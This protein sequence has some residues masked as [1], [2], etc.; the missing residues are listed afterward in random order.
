MDILE[1]VIEEIQKECEAQ[2]REWV[3]PDICGVDAI[4][5]RDEREVWVFVD[6]NLGRVYVKNP[7]RYFFNLEILAEKCL[8]ISVIKG[9]ESPAFSIDKKMLE[10]FVR[11]FFKKKRTSKCIP[12]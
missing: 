9:Y 11:W 6:T 8:Y 5:R 4:F 3:E 10:K 12:K 1:L 7:I 2:G